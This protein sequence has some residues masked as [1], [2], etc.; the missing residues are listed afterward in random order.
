MIKNLYIIRHGQADHLVGDRYTGGWTNSMLTDLG[1][2][3][4]RLTGKRLS[5]LM[6]Q[7]EFDFFCSDLQRAVETATIIGKYICSKPLPDEALRELNNGDAANLTTEEAKKIAF[8]IT[9]PRID[10]VHYPNAESWRDMTNRVFGFMNNISENSKEN[11]V[12]VTH[13]G[14]VV[15]IIDWW[16]ELNEN[17][18]NKISY[19]ID[20]CSITYLRVNKWGERTISK[21]NDTAHM[22]K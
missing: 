3:Q 20:P 4:A 11:V 16:L 21:M 13:R 6:L 22:G 2:K 8:P 19:D 1:R 10:W 14:I 7:G 12:I 9:E 15:S 17:Y 5:E 18:I